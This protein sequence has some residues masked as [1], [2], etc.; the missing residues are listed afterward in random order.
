MWDEF[1]PEIEEWRAMGVFGPAVPVPENTSLQDR[2][3]GLAGRDPS[4]G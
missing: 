4:V 2:L 3:P 1:V